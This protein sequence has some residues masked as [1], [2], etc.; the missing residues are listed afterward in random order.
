MRFFAVGVL[1]TLIDFAGFIAFHY[2]LGVPPVPSHMFG[3]ILA[4]ANSFILNYKWTFRYAGDETKTRLIIRFVSIA[5]ILL[6]ISSV[7]L[8]VLK[9]FVP[10]FLSKCLVVLVMVPIS[11]FANTRFVFKQSL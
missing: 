10:V 1:N 11:Y 9:I 2:S 4:V 3:F 8:W 6:I 5:V 7:I